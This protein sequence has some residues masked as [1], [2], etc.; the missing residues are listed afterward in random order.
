MGNIS[1]VG[2][3]TGDF[4]G[5]DLSDKR[6]TVVVINSE[7]L[8][9]EEDSVPVTPAGLSS[10]LSGRDRSRVAIE[11]GTH[12][13]WVSRI[14]EG[15]G[16]EVIVANS[17]QI[18]LIFRSNRKNDRV[19]ATSLARL[20]RLDPELLHPMKH[21]TEKAQEDLAVLRSRD[22]LVK[23]RTSLVNHVRGTVKA[24]GHR[25]PSCSAG[26][27]ATRVAELLPEGLRDA[28][29]PVVETIAGLTARIGDYDSKVEELAETRYREA[30]VLK[31]VNGVGPLTSLAFVLT[32]EDPYRFRRSRD[33]GAFLG[34]TPRQRQ[35]GATNL[36]L[37]ISKAGD[38]F[39]RRLLVQCAHYVLGP[40][41]QDSD[42]RRWGLKLATGGSR[43]RA[44]IA[45]ARKLAVLLQ[46]LWVTGEVYE[47]LRQSAA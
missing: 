22:A 20:A 47:P 13:P 27:F 16:H 40:F 17:R 30:A 1:T 3:G 36:Q 25:L 7:G 31:Q 5:M 11:A 35:S 37:H 28:L 42:L 18:P 2:Q 29:S 4:I 19:D 12:S 24:L 23:A 6:A 43:K 21:R 34:L 9:V 14:I 15:S 32:L 45:V 41:G 39:L 38:A 33:V 8:V 46:R 44:T 26:A 10:Y